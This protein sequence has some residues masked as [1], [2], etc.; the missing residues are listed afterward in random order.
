[1]KLTALGSLTVLAVAVAACS[2]SAGNKATTAPD[3]DAGADGGGDTFT[4]GAE[5][6][7]AV[8]AGARTYV[9]LASPPAVVT[10]ADPATDKGWD[11]AF[12]GLDVFTNSGPSGSGSASAFGPLDPIIFLDDVAPTVPFLAADTTGGAFIRWWFYGGAPDHALYTRY[13][14]YGIKDGDKQY[15]VQ[16]L[17]YYGVRDGAPV[18]AIYKVRWAEVTQAGSGPTKEIADLDGTAGGPS[19]KPTDKSECLDLGT[20]A[21]VMLTPAEARTSSAWHLCFRRQ[22][23]SVNGEVGGPRNVGAVDL[24]ADK[25]A[26]DTLASVVAKTDESELPRFDAVNAASLAGQ[27]FRG[28]RVVSAFGTL[29]LA[30]GATPPTPAK[31]AWVVYGADSTSKYLVGFSRFEGGDNVQPATVV[32]R[33]KSVN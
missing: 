8:S 33:V 13:H 23:I 18:S 10:P 27:A 21:R 3:G 20:S 12:Q 25:I 5:L 29:W 22:D 16:V 15:K 19:G 1:M 7:V 4:S 26:T 9:K 28:D 17:Q 32:M 30:R 24:D 6:K 14:L 11:L 31:N 2:D